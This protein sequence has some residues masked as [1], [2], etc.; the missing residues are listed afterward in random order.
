M[1]TLLPPPEKRAQPPFTQ[2]LA[3]VYCGQMGGWIKVPLGTEVN[4]GPGDTVLDVI[5]APPS[6]KGH[7]PPVFGPWILWPHGWMDED[8]TW[9]GSRPRTR[10]H[11]V[12]LGPSSP[13]LPRKGDSSHPLLVR[14]LLWPWSP[15]SAT[16]ELLL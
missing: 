12:R 15:I 9:Y 3:H 10:P 13:H 7:S 16:A 14:C 5:A 6:L 4:L 1:E 2:F 8:A 11:C